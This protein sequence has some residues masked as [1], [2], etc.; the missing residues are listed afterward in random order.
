MD[1]GEERKKLYGKA[2]AMRIKPY[3]VE[4]RTPSNWWTF[5]DERCMWVWDATERALN[6]LKI[7]HGVEDIVQECINTNNKAV[8]ESLVNEFNLELV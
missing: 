6:N 7:H 5:T 4:Y 1:D 8:A 2:G 3:G